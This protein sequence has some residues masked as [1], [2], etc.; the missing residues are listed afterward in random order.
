MRPVNARSGRR[1]AGCWSKQAWTKCR[2]ACVSIAR[3]FRKGSGQ[4]VRLGTPYYTAPGC[5]GPTHCG[6]FI[7]PARSKAQTLRDLEGGAFLLNHR[8]SNSGMNLPR[9]S[10]AAGAR[11]LF[12]RV[13]ET[14]SQPGNLDRIGARRGRRDGGRRPRSQ[15]KLVDVRRPRITNPSGLRNESTRASVAWTGCAAS[16]PVSIVSAVDRSTDPKRRR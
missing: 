2:R 4:A 14:G 10:L 7:V 3:R 16:E 15:A 8:H 1:C 6:F 5:D 11:P 9:R 13:V 12:S